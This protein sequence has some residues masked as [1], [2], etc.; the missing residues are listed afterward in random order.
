MNLLKENK[1]MVLLVCL[2]A[3]SRFLPHPPN[4]SA[5]GALA[6]FG[7]AVWRDKKWAM[8]IPVVLMIVTDVA[9]GLHPNMLFVYGSFLLIAAL[10]RWL[11][12]PS[13]AKVGVSAVAASGLFFAVTNFGVWLTMPLYPKTFAGLLQSYV[14]G[15]PF[16]HN[17]LV[18]NLLF[19]AVL[20]SGYAFVSKL[21]RSAEA[22]VATVN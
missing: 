10:G 20:F 18:S 6:L 3:L 21:N 15:I 7:G 8:F 1:L 11:S 9:V 17:T 16:F 4:F 13:V 14:A 2:V 19:S 12:T 5:V 22:D